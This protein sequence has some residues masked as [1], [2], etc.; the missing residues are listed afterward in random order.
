MKNICGR[1]A[2]LNGRGFA[3]RKLWNLALAA[4]GIFTLASSWAAT[5]R[6]A[7]DAQAANV[8]ATTIQFDSGASIST[9]TWQNRR[10]QEKIP[11]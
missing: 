7:Q 11:L 5:P 1:A 3:Q 8:D 9:H 2:R 10:A 4:V 6:S